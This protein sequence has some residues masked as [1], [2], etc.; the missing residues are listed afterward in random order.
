MNSKIVMI[1]RQQS[2]LK[3]ANLLIWWKLTL[4]GIDMKMDFVY[5]FAACGN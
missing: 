5:L 4:I 3:I 1:K 2:R